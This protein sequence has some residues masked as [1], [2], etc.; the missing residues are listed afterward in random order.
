MNLFGEPE[1]GID[2]IMHQ[3]P[4]GILVRHYRQNC[5][6]CNSIIFRQVVVSRKLFFCNHPCHA[7][8]LSRTQI[9][10]NNSNWKGGRTI[11]IQNIRSSLEYQEWRT[12]VFK[13]DD[14]TC[15]DC[16]DHNGGNLEAHHLE[17]IFQ[18]NEKIFDID[19]G[20]TLCIPCHSKTR[21][22]ELEYLE[23][24]LLI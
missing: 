16:S 9:G 21:G 18:S 23:E 4:S 20:R 15:Q 17:A 7:D 8:Y 24:L 1:L 3:Q 14:Y 10:L 11:W 12:A 5:S 2:Y 13:R 22:H 19:N 6:E